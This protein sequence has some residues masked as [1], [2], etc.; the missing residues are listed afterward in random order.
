MARR[1]RPTISGERTGTGTGAA[2][3]PRPAFGRR[4]WLALLRRARNLR[5]FALAMGGRIPAGR[6]GDLVGAVQVSA[7]GWAHRPVAVAGS[8]RAR[9]TG[10]RPMAL[11]WGMVIGGRSVHAR[12]MV[13][14]LTVV[15]IDRDG[16]V[17]FVRRLRPGGLAFMPGA[18]AVLE[19]PG[20]LPT[21][22]PGDILG[23]APIDDGW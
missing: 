1:S 23:W 11:G 20:H 17:V 10:L 21:P 2:A 15:G 16:I 3:Q 18:A 19:L 6:R 22:S 14:P 8:L 7:S 4:P 9:R 13:E 12:G 5:R